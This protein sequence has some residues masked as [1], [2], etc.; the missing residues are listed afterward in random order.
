MN[1]EQ[2]PLRYVSATQINA[3][4]PFDLPYPGHYELVVTTPT[5]T[6]SAHET[7]LSGLAPAIYTQNATGVGPA[8]VFDANFNPVKQVSTTPLILYASGLGPTNPP[9]SVTGGNSTEPFNRTVY[10]P[11]VRIGGVPAQIL[12]AGLAPG[13]PGIYQLNVIPSSTTSPVDNSL[14]LGFLVFPVGSPGPAGLTTL[15][16]AE[17]SN[18]AN[19]TGSLSTTFPL[20]STLLTYSPLVTAAKFTA[21]LDILPKA[22]PFNLVAS[23]PGGSLIVALNPGAGT[24]QAT[25]NV[26]TAGMRSGDFNGV[27]NAQGSYIAILDFASNLP[28]AGNVIPQSRL[29]PAALQAMSAIPLPNY[30]GT[31]AGVNLLL[32]GTIPSGGHFVIN[33]SSNSNLS[34]FGG[35]TYAG[36]PGLGGEWWRANTCSLTVDGV[37]ISSSLVTFQ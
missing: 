32:Q 21:A 25:T 37:L 28:F 27:M 31:I 24:W 11:L 17:G 13:L 4:I 35:F 33:D 5:G 30:T 3:L 34:N 18:T 26:P 14:S 12:F 22:Q 1:G 16:V 7:L 29:D 20:S 36:T 2:L 10:T 19:L 23:C 9:G 6:S 15:P 8:L